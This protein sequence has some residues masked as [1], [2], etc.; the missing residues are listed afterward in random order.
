MPEAVHSL[1]SV[2]CLPGGFDY[3]I[4]KCTKQMHPL[5]HVF[6]DIYSFKGTLFNFQEMY[7]CLLAIC[8]LIAM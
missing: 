5:N 8:E 6:S 7:M 1:N 2:V 4:S 3:R